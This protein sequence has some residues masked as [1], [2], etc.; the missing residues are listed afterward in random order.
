MKLKYILYTLVLLGIGAMIYYRIDKN[1]ELS[2]S[3]KPK[4][5]FTK[6]IGVNGIV[7]KAREFAN[8][9]SV[10]GSIGANEQVQLRSQVAGIITQI[11]FIEGRFVKKGQTL[12]KIDDSELQA[13]LSEI[14]IRETLASEN[15]KRANSLLKKEGISKEEYEI[16]L[17][18]MKSLQAQA[19][20]IRTQLAKTLIK[21]PF[22]GTIGLRNVSV[23]EY[24][25]TTT[26]I[27][28]LVNTNPVKITFSVPEKYASSMK[29]N[30]PVQFTFAGSTKTY[31][32]TIYAIE[33]EI[34]ALT[35]TMQLRAKASNIDG[36]LLA[37][38]F[39]NIQL[40]LTVIKNALLVPTEA[41]IPIQDGKKVFIVKN[42]KAKEAVVETS[43]R[44]D[45][46]VLILS[47]LQEGDTVLTTGVMSMKP[48]TAVKVTLTNVDQQAQ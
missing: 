34:D 47:G 37:G 16:T 41:V 38:S 23:G 48:G 19:Q 44:T 26:I 39:A 25:S 17:S 8:I 24:L 43:S 3:S 5:M 27:A 21:A 29:V 12:V 28:N 45:K 46:D 13:Q 36:V 6:S 35:R 20:I 4:G 7:L 9:I 18:A 30:T 10:S 40:P 14:L 22:D 32:A 33:P 1:K 11:Y 2:D 31:T 42:G 15:E